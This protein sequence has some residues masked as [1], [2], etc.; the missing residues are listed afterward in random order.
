MNIEHVIQSANIAFYLD[1]SIGFL[2][3]ALLL[4]YG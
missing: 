4:Y 3:R 2:R 1:A